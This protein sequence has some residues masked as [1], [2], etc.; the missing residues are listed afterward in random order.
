M[1]NRLDWAEITSRLPRGC[2][3]S[4]KHKDRDSGLVLL[5]GV[6]GVIE[7]YR[8]TLRGSICCKD[9]PW[10]KSSSAQRRCIFRTSSERVVAVI[11][12]EQCKWCKGLP[13]EPGPDYRL[14]RANDRAYLRRMFDLSPAD[15]SKLSDLLYDVTRTRVVL[16]SGGFLFAG[17]PPYCTVANVIHLS[18]TALQKVLEFDRDFVWGH[19]LTFNTR[20]NANA[21]CV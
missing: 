15:T 7:S 21:H 14:E 6:L 9:N 3:S 11:D 16:L 17:T 4:A 13:T 19:N 12:G 20:A 18:G 10:F 5:D 8:L 1:C 2:S